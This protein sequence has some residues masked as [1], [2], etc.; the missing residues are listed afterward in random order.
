MKQRITTAVMMI[1]VALPILVYGGLPFVIFGGLLT[2]AAT[3]EMITMR[4]K[5]VSTPLEIKLLTKIA[6]LVVV[7]H[8]FDFSTFSINDHAAI[9]LELVAILL[10]TLLLA[11]VIRKSFTSQ[12]A[13]YYLFT[14]FYVGATFHSMLYV[15]MLGLDLFLFMILVV[16]LTDSFA[17]FIGRKFGKRKL[18]PLISPKKTLEGSIGGTLVG[19]LTGVIFGI[20]TNLMPSL[21]MLVFISFIVSIVGQVGDLVASSMKREY[22][23]KDYGKLFPGH[24]G[25]L[26]RLDSQLF[27]SLA[28]YLVINLLSVVI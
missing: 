26:D 4:E 19:T 6:T 28:L 12:D 1:V 18:A 13:A 15:R 8:S 5:T 11:V 17:Y 21:F 14:I 10:V 2:L 16:A 9:N 24:G 23:I 7:F 25:V 22:Q 20:L 3:H 27:A